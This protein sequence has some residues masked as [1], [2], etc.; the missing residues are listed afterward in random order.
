MEFFNR[1]QRLRP[2]TGSGS[3]H[4]DQLQP[5]IEP[6]SLCSRE[7]PLYEVQL[8]QTFSRCCYVERTGS[9]NPEKPIGPPRKCMPLGTPLRRFALAPQPIVII[10]SYP[11]K[12]VRGSLLPAGKEFAHTSW[13][14]RNAKFEARS[15]GRPAHIRAESSAEKPAYKARCGQPLHP[16]AKRA[17]GLA[18]AP[19]DRAVA[20]RMR[21]LHLQQLQLATFDP[22]PRNGLWQK[23]AA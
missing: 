13:P 17:A 6:G 18:G 14:H 23:A 10:G 2:V 16:P 7:R 4:A 1:I 20:R 3:I 15:T 22:W 19:G 5:A 21:S 9:V 11:S 12:D 8:T